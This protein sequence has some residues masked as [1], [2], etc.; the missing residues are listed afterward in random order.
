MRALDLADAVD[1]LLAEEARKQAY[2]GHA[3]RVGKLFKAVLPDPVAN[4]V[5]PRRALI[6]EL[7]D[8]IRAVTPAADIYD[9]MSEVETL[10]DASVA[11]EGYVIRERLEEHIDLSR[12]DV[13]ALRERF[14]R[15]RKHIETEK[16]K[17]ALDRKLTRMVRLNPGR[18]DFLL[19]FQRLID[20]YNTHAMNIEELFR[21]LLELTRDLTDEEQRGLREELSEEELTLFDI[22]TRPEMKLSKKEERQVKKAARELLRSLKE[23]KLVL[24]W[25]KRQ[26][27]RAQVRVGIE[28]VMD[29]SLPE[30]Y[31]PELF[32]QKCERLYQHI[33]DA[34]YGAGASIY[35]TA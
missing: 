4:Q 8:A 33:F 29:H 15:G 25:R 2:L 10:L 16:L 32:Q 34:Y 3:R 22:L 19:R 6:Q 9:V 7:A 14:Q 31:T 5:V 1:T 26:Q 30:A 35:Q 23:G 20:T 18:V 13:E 21:A 11:A 28:T 12:L 17:S 27:A 24:D